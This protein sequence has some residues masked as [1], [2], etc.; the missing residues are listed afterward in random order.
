V[1]YPLI[2]IFLLLPISTTAQ[3]NDTSLPFRS[4][5]IEAHFYDVL[6]QDPEFMKEG[7][8]KVFA[9][10]DGSLALI[11]IGK[12]FSENN[13]HEAM[14][15]ERRKGEILARSAILFLSGDIE[16]STYQ[17]LKEECFT[18]KDRK[19]ISLSSFFHVTEI[20]VKGEIQ[21]LSV[22]GSWWSLD[23][24]TFYL[25]VGKIMNDTGQQ[26]GMIHHTS[27]G[28]K[29]EGLPYIEGEEPFV[30][31]LQASPVLMRYGG[32]Q[33][34]NLGKNTR[35]ILAVGSAAIEGSYAKARRIAKLK[36]VLSLLGT[37]EG[38]SISSVE[39]LADY[40][41]VKIS[42]NEEERVSLSEFLSVNKEKISGL[43]KTMPVV[44]TW[45]E[46]DGNIL[47]VVI[48]DFF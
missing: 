13:K 39:S 47:H 37:L 19:T 8:A 48:G 2:F 21:Q 5:A 24:G 18:S 36:A 22:V 41:Y 44:A 23:H 3:A 10:N 26:T 12:V 40:E 15:Q 45:K 28:K 27:T 20:R 43:V 32:V 14:L 7:G 9:L 31:L 1:F 29:T 34:F 11:G 30:S 46:K 25:A 17:G 35:V 42:K 38:V 6:I 4:I 33:G 16:I